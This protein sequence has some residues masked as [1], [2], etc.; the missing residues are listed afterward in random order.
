MKKNINFEAALSRLEEIVTTLENGIDELD[1]VVS[2]YEEG[3]ELTEYCNKKL[4]KIENKIEI[5]SEK[6]SKNNPGK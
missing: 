3:M 6:I 5:L 1:K 4:E 2:L